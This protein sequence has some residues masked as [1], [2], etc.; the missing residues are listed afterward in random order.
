MPES[1]T[2]V[3]P[4]YNGSRFL[5]RAVDSVLAA[6]SGPDEIII[7]DDG[8]GD[9]SFELAKTIERSNTG[10]VRCL[11]HPQGARRGVSATRN[12]GILAS[13][14]DWIAFL[15]AD[16]YYYPNRFVSSRDILGRFPDI[17]GLYE[18]SEIV[19]DRV[20]QEVKTWTPG[21]CG[22]RDRLTGAEL[23]SQLVFSR[24]W[25]PSGILIRKRLLIQAGLFDESLT[26]GEDCHLWMKAVC[27]GNI[28]PGDLKAPVAAYVRHG[29]NVTDQSKMTRLHTMHLA[30]MV[31]RWA[32]S[33]RDLREYVPGVL[34]RAF[35][36]LAVDCMMEMRA[37]GQH[38][39]AWNVVGCAVCTRWRM[40]LSFGM[41]RQIQALLR[42]SI[43]LSR[44]PCRG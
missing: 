38:R 12:L 40:A 17:D 11:Q 30:A 42:E 39:L 27:L 15:D 28:V 18:T 32:R 20:S 25:L 6:E 21:V 14:S 22:I 44:S 34:N 24:A 3:I 29:D 19:W 23:L 36:A 4:V 33:R 31:M 7:I 16:D 13:K 37:K 26:I 10:R 1:I 41:W 35:E 9:G 8:S 5:G 2:V 43:G